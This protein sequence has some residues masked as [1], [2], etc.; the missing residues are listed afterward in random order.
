[1][2]RWFEPVLAGLCLGYVLALALLWARGQWILDASGHP[3]KVDFLSFHAAGWFA[4]HGR[5]IAAYDWRKIHAFHETMV[6]APFSGFFGW[7]YPPL[8]FPLV[9]VLA[10]LPY[11]MAFFLWV[12][13][14]LAL[15]AWGLWRIGGRG[16]LLLGLALPPILGNA[17]VGQNGFLTAALFA[18]ALLT[19]PRKP[20]LSALLIALLTYKPHFGILIPVALMAGGYWR[21]LIAATVLVLLHAAGCWLL[22]PDLAAAFLHNLVQN[23]GMFLADGSAGF[24]KLQSL[25]GVLRGLGASSLPA[26]SAQSLLTVG[27][28]VLLAMLWRRGIAFPLKAAALAVSALLAM[29]YVYF[30]DLPLLSVALAFLWRDRPFEKTEMAAILVMMLLLGLCALV[31]APLGLPAVAICAGLVVRRSRMTRAPSFRPS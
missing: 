5:A 15:L 4:D 3:Q 7:A 24:F 30:Y 8:F 1:M 10:L 6:G 13:A 17:L 12:V 16:A 19:L 20:L 11:A 14:S 22:M 26:W 28:A 31:T 2:R 27:T 25:Y 18:G 21:A 23:N 29:P 9:M